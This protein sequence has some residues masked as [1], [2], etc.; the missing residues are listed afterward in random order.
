MKIVID[1]DGTLCDESDPDMSKRTPYLERIAKL[2]V[3]YYAGNTI[4]IYTSRGMNST[5]DD[6]IASDLK[7]R[8]FTEDQLSSWGVKY[9]KLVFGK[10][11]ADVYI[12]N[13]NCLLE[14]FFQE[15]RHSRSNC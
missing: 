13:K 8:K 12:D 1:I 15:P 5:S 2:K 7:Y 6:P 3:L 9:H 14:D 11:N 4:I 10:P